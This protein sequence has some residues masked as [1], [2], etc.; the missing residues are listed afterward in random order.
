M[1]HFGRARAL[2]CIALLA[3]CG[4]DKAPGVEPAPVIG[5]IVIANVP[6]APVIIGATVQL[7]GLATN[8]AG[9]SISNATFSWTTSDGRI[10]TVSTAGLVTAVGAAPVTITATAGG[11]SASATLD[12]RAGA[13]LSPA[14][15]SLSFIDG[16]VRL[17]VPSGAV[18]ET[19]NILVRPITDAATTPRLL[20]G[21]V[22]ELAPD[23]PFR[24]P[25]TLLL[26]YPGS[27]LPLGAD[28]ASLQL[29]RLNGATWSPVRFSSSLTSDRA[30]SGSITRSGTYAVVSTPVDRILLTGAP[31]D[32]AAF[33]GQTWTYRAQV[34]DALGDSL[35][36][37]AIAWT[38]SAPGVATVTDG[39][40]T[41]VGP[42][43][44]TITATADGKSAS[45]T[46]A[47]LSRPTA[48]WSSARDWSTYQG[49][50]LRNGYMPVTLD[51]VV[52]SP[53]WSR[54][55]FQDV[56]LTPVTEGAGG[57]YTATLSYFSNQRVAAVDAATGAPRWS[58]SF[59]NIHGVHPPAFDGGRVFTTTSGHQDS[60]LY[61]FDAATGAQRFRTSY[62]NQFSRY[63]S[64]AVV[65]GIVYMAGGDYDGLYTFDA[66]SGAE[67]WFIQ[68]A[69]YDQWAPSVRNGVVYAYTGSYAPKVIAV[70][71]TTGALQYEIPDPGFNWNGWS[72]NTAPV[73]GEENDLLA[74]Q[75][76]RLVSFD[77]VAR[78]VRYQFKSSFRGTVSV[79]NG[80]VYVLD[81]GLL[82]VRR[83][84]DGVLLWSWKAPEGLSSNI[85]V[86]D[87]LIFVS[88]DVATYAVDIGS[89]RPVWS[90]PAGG[91]LTLSSQGLLLTAG[92]SGVLT[93]I[94]VK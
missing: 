71:A 38:S 40:V 1:R 17:N 14:G 11:K 58:F 81:G 88:S 48:N 54:T 66:T 64:P 55:L 94:G 2:V 85:I 53:R 7:V 3:A 47:V 24:L 10:A 45:A 57:L 39:R 82:D 50:A 28:S 29:Y 46:V 20:A 77:L 16:A 35:R 12:I 69:Q 25:V 5:A 92:G 70:N 44:C 72:M 56:P 61:A 93:A 89:H 67:R 63:Y 79:A 41:A 68:T 51:P 62:G 75:N 90:H 73:L 74:T 76:G 34:Y 22:F 86:T 31:A 59:G 80:Q 19:V 78:R 36:G 65:N 49:N 43:T 42:G 87:N 21:T 27:S 6:T 91:P 84:S 26:R 4:G 32:V 52:F 60:Y 30:V 23:F 37:L 8:A 9:G 13:A 15:G 18:T 83:E 33:S